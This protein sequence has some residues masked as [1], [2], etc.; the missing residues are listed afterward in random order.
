MKKKSF[1]QDIDSVR[2]IQEFVRE[3]LSTRCSNENRLLKIDLV[4]EEIIVNIVQYGD[5][6]IQN[7]AIDVEVDVADNNI[8]L[9]ISDG[10][11]SFNP[12]EL[13]NPDIKAG[14]DQRRPG[15]LGIFFVKQIANEIQYE[16][17]DN[18]NI[19]KLCLDL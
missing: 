19:L 2:Q 11:P 14:L 3:F 10:G 18:R 9:E 6:D 5:T 4:I 12:L 8:I 7:S 15:G 16:R 17:K 13:E 1:A